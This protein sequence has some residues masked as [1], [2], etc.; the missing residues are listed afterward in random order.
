M[1]WRYSWVISWREAKLIC[2]NPKDG[3]SRILSFYD[4]TTG[5]D[6]GFGS[7]ISSLTSAKANT[8][9]TAN[10]LQAYIDSQAGNMFFDEASD[11]I[12]HK[13]K[14]KI[15]AYREKAAGIEEQIKAKVQE[16]KNTAI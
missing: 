14:A 11:E 2:K 13:F 3:V 8:T 4:K 16:L 15:S 12:V 6:Y 5:L 1:F 10:R 7:L 9:I